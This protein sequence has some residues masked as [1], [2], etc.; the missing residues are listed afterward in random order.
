MR[1]LIMLLTILSATGFS[2]NSTKGTIKVRKSDSVYTLVDKM[3]AFPGGDAAL[4]RYVSANVKYP[5]S[6]LDEGRS[7]TVYICFTVNTDGTISDAVVLRGASGCPECDK[8]A[9]R[10]I[11]NLPHFS[12][13][14]KDGAAVKAK[15][16]LPIKFSLG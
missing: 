6:A 9:L 5:Q 16:W 15:F 3:P 4:S 11:Q 7:G 2:Q 14:L 10:V 8:E 12:P 13:A 1:S